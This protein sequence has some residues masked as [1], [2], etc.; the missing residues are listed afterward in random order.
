MMIAYMIVPEFIYTIK[1]LCK[2]YNHTT[3]SHAAGS[4]FINLLIKL[5]KYIMRG[6]NEN[7]K[8][9]CRKNSRKLY[10]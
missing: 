6:H 8:N 1:Q 4:N 2:T 5:E 10:M 3:I 9:N 7:N